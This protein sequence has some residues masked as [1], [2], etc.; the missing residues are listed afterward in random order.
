M[1][2]TG[3]SYPV[4]TLAVLSCLTLATLLL[5]FISKIINDNI[6]LFFLV[7]GITAI[8]VSGLWNI[9]IIIEA[10]KSPVSV[11]GAPIG[12]FQ[13]VLV[14]GILLHYLNRYFFN[15]IMH[16]IGKL[17]LKLFIF[18]FI[19]LLGL[20]S[21]VFSVVITAVILAE[22]L[23]ILPFARP[24][25]LKMAVV[26]CFAIGMGAG[27][28]PI[29]E[30]LSTIMVHKLA[31]APYYA[32]FFFPLRTIGVYIIPGIFL[33]AGFG[34]IFITRSRPVNPVENTY[35]PESLKEVIFRA[36]RIYIFIVALVLLGQGL[37]PLFMTFLAGMQPMLL[38]WI[39]IVSAF[40]DNA[41]LTAIEINPQLNEPQ[42]ISAIIALLISGGILIPG[43]IPN[44]VVA[45]RLRISMK[46]WALT[47]VPIGMV[48]LL[49]YFIIIL[50]CI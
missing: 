4:V 24:E 47:G 32:E 22:V 10:I 6:E 39:N 18:L 46:E 20:L 43:N 19:L 38:Y 29:G 13:V 30:P 44:I 1:E 35:I 25:R 26:S 21:S 31:G 41:T 3:H 8:T 17:D 50:I 42:I 7:M 33:I 27:L 49:L 34:S 40:L 36:I 5:P 9:E 16:I 23:Y 15:V 12:I 28:T 48:L 11:A 45:G 14:F 37:T 2:V